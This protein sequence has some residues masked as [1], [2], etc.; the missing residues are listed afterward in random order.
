MP[1]VVV[2]NDTDG[3]VNVFD[4]NI[5]NAKSLAEGVLLANDWTTMLNDPDTIRGLLSRCDDSQS[6]LDEME[7]EIGDEMGG[8]SN[9]NQ[10]NVI[11]SEED[12]TA[13]AVRGF[14]T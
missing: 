10:V 8:R 2:I 4:W 1:K 7:D 9:G 14:L 3:H 6:W 12:L 11:C 5:S 13:G